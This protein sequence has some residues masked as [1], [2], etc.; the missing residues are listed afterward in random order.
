[1]KRL[2]TNSVPQNKIA[3]K[4]PSTLFLTLLLCSLSSKIDNINAEENKIRPL[5]DYLLDSNTYNKAD[6][7]RLDRPT[8]DRIG[9][10]INNFDVNDADRTFKITF[11][12]RQSWRDERLKFNREITKDWDVAEDIKRGLTQKIQVSANNIKNR[13]FLPDV[14]FR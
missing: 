7:P 5:A 11:Y 1:M 9:L 10:Y 13:M 3:I 14:F 2:T 4:M 8:E 6:P 12:L